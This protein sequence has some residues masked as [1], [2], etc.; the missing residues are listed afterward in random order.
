MQIQ[1]QTTTDVC[2]TFLNLKNDF[3]RNYTDVYTNSPFVKYNGTLS[4]KTEFLSFHLPEDEDKNWMDWNSAQ[5]YCKK[6]GSELA[7][8]TS[9]EESQFFEIGE[10]DGFWERTGKRPISHWLGGRDH[11]GQIFLKC[12]SCKN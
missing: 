12:A 7:W 6:L 4:G 10:A 5:K 8:I 9:R 2:Q 3:F 11:S 1:N